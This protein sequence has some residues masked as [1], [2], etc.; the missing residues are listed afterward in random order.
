MKDTKKL[1]LMG[2]FVSMALVLH[3]VERMIPVPFIAPG[4]KLG[5]SNIITLTVLMIFGFKDAFIVL[6]TRV[7]LASIFGGGVSSFL[8]SIVGGILS[9]L[10]MELIKVVGRE[11]VSLIGISVAGAVFHNVGQ[12]LVA[13]FII[14]N[15]NIFI[16]FPILFLA[17]VGTGIFIGLT[18]K[19]LLN[20]L[21]LSS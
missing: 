10:I 13:A 2:L 1:V 19:C 15:I 20:Y 12:L 11:N 14:K 5:L 8:Y 17:A 9:I 7:I 6:I 4:A 16:Y 18:S 3:L 21:T